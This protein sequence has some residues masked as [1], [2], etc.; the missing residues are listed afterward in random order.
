MRVR[1]ADAAH[2]GTGLHRRPGF[3]GRDGEPGD[4]RGR[5]VHPSEPMMA[6]VLLITL[7]QQPA[8]PAD[9]AAGRPCKVI[10]D[11]VGRQARQVE[12]RRGETNVFAGGGV[13]A[14]CEGTGSTLA[15]DSVAWFAGTGRF[16]MI[17]LASQVHIRDTAITLDGR[18]ASYYLRPER[19]EA[20]NRA[21][22]RN[23]R[24][25]SARP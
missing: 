21:G 2:Q 19:L 25:G 5:Q 1:R 12:V 22:A 3:Q 24:T 17:G 10:I 8:A 13:L 4:G 18:F 7:V 6:T 14:H 20:P 15:A 23:A 9:T 16:D 11:S